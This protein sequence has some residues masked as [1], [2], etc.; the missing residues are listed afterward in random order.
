MDNTNFVNHLYQKDRSSYENHVND[1]RQIARGHDDHHHDDDD[2]DDH[3]DGG[4][5]DV[6][7]DGAGH[8]VHSVDE[9]N[10]SHPLC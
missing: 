10:L 6:I 2:D 9:S 8:K 4:R 1:G 7:H 5:G 3:H